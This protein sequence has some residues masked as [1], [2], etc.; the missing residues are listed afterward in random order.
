M[1]NSTTL[2][3][4]H[5]LQY[6]KANQPISICVRVIINNYHYPAGSPRGPKSVRLNNFPFFPFEPRS[7]PSSPSETPSL[8]NTRSCWYARLMGSD[9]LKSR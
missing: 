9:C 2:E 7:M 3:A 6:L 5:S 4:H 8:P 1:Q